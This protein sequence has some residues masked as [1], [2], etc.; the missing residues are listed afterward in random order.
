MCEV[1]NCNYFW[2]WKSGGNSNKKRFFKLRDFFLWS[3]EH[4]EIKSA[5][6]Q[7][8]G[9]SHKNCLIIN[10]KIKDH[11]WVEK[12]NLRRNKDQEIPSGVARTTDE[13]GERFKLSNRLR[14]NYNQIN[15][16]LIVLAVGDYKKRFS[17]T[18]MVSAILSIV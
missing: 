8:T 13:R 11:F 7:L 16:I 12:K 17:N 3:S 1:K 18:I 10:H 4:F 9:G 6:N 14:G 15:S 2:I 5:V